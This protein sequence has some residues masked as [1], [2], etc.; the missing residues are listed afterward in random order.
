VKIKFKYVPAIAALLITFVFPSAQAFGAH[1]AVPTSSA[2]LVNGKLK[3]FDSYNINGYNYFKLRDIAYVLNGTAKQFGIDWMTTDGTITLRPGS[4]YVTLGDEMASKATEAKTASPSTRKVFVA[5]NV[6]QI[7]FE[8]YNID[9]YNY[10]KLR[11]IGIVMDMGIG[12]DEAR[13]TISIDSTKGYVESQPF[14]PLDKAVAEA[15]LSRNKGFYGGGGDF[16]CQA[17]ITLLTVQNGNNITDYVIAF[18]E[19]LKKTG[20]VIVSAGGTFGPAAITFQLNSAGNYKLT[21]YWTPDDGSRYNITIQD[22]FPKELWDKVG[23]QF[24]VAALMS[25]TNAQARAHYD[26]QL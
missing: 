20:N 6:N 13:N 11:D 12:W 24:Y 18:Y 15:I 9:G 21:E 17:H 23:A 3:T 22:K 14:T 10:F 4:L 2:V 19:E 25:N 8:A 1:S 26:Q 7:P 5:G 16:F